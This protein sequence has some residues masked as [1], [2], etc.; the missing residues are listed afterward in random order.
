VNER[1][2]VVSRSQ[3][4]QPAAGWRTLNSWIQRHQ[5]HPFVMLVLEGRLLHVI[6]DDEAKV[7]AGLLEGCYVLETDVQAEQLDPRTVDERYR[8][9]QRVERDFRNLKT[10]VLEGRPIFLRKAA[11]RRGH[12]FVALLALK[13]FRALAAPLQQAFGTAHD[14]PYTLTVEDALA[15]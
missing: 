2:A 8:D 15:T 4:A 5:L 12:V 14:E 3:R 11:R 1:P 7:T 6:S 13:L 10:V 9:L